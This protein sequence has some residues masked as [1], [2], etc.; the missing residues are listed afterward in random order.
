MPF[1]FRGRTSARHKGINYRG[2]VANQWS[3]RELLRHA[4]SDVLER[5]VS[6]HSQSAKVDDV[7]LSGTYLV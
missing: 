6:R 1:R 3:C 4:M 7:S 5:A 2:H